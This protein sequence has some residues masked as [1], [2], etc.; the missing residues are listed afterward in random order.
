MEKDDILAFQA[1]AKYGSFTKASEALFIA[2]PTLSKKVANLE[3]ELGL[4]LVERTKRYARLTYAGIVFL[5]ESKSLL[6]QEKK[7]VDAVREAA[8][9]G[10]QSLRVGIMGTGLARKCLPFIRAFKAKHPAVVIH[11]D[12]L[13]FRQ[14]QDSLRT[15]R[16]DC[17]I[18]GDL[19]LSLL[20]P[21]ETEEI[22]RSGHTLL[23]PADHPFLT[24]KRKVFRSLETEPFLVLQGKSSYKGPDMV[25][26]ICAGWGFAPK[27]E[28][29][30][31]TVEEILFQVEAGQ[32]IAILPSF[33]CPPDGTM[34]LASIPL[35][36][37][38][39][40]LPTVLAWNGGN[41]NP[42]LLLWKEELRGFLE[43]KKSE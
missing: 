24:K 35:T 31:S 34:N 39:K 3:H 18:A 5:E 7:M 4:T 42:A 20:D 14:I 26:S 40:T 21:L 9:A 15:S 1:L 30:C 8:R 23:L 41:K 2:Q 38:T 36:E 43:G 12:L 10:A 17:A 37:E 16:L 29:V 13:D 6:A 11:L 32:G 27:I 22:G 25:K 33:D 19:G 28:K